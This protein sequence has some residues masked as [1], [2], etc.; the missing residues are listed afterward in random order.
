MQETAD[1]VIVGGG[2]IGASVA[3]HLAKRKAGS[4]LLL[5]REEVLGAGSTGKAAGGVRAQFSTEINTRMSL[6]SIGCFERWQDEIGE[7]L[8]FWQWGYAF[9]LTSDELV[10]SFRK[11]RE[12]W[13]RLGMNVEW[14]SP[15]ETAQRLPYVNIDGVQGCTF[16][17]RDGFG[18]PNDVTQG[19]AKR[20]QQ[21]GVKIENRVEV[22]GVELEGGRKVVAVQTNKGRVA[23]GHLILCTGAWTR[24]VAGMC[25]VDV[26]IDPIRRQIIVTDEFREIADPFP[27]TVDL[28][29]TLYFHRESS[30][31]LIGMSDHS[32]S[33]GF[34]DSFNED[35][36]E[37]ML[38]AAMER[39]PVLENAVPKH[40]WAGFYEVTPDHHAVIDKLGHVSNACVCAGF[41]GHGL[42]HAPAAGLLTAELALDGK[43]STLDITALELSRFSD[44]TR[45]H[46]EANVI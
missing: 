21:L 14:W 25:G 31:V 35:F 34:D 3:Y 46:G 45:L 9:L 42:M 24:R 29:T 22:T 43:A 40:K 5:E 39:A 1:F 10:A 26:P 28:S 18:D 33:A 13:T 11:S 36:G 19:Y 16:H 38:I 27:M 4:V 2:C 37:Q 30:G 41:S 20:A 15:E 17:Q 7:P 6:H 12:M 8:Q 23:C 44:P 32:E